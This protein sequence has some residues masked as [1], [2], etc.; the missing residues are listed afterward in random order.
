MAKFFADFSSANV[1]ARA[2]G[3]PYFSMKFC[4][5]TFDDSNCA[6][7]WFGP[8]MRR[9]FGWN[10]STMPS[11]SGLSGPT[12]VRSGFFSLAKASNCGKSSAR[13]ST[14]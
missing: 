3:M 11:A 8:Q 7:F 6:A 2:V 14:H 9:P 10:K 12:T 1:A 5:K 13:M 4:E